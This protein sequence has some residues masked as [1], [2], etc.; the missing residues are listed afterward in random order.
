L[1]LLQLMQIVDVCDSSVAAIDLPSSIPYRLSTDHEPAVDA[2]LPA[3]AVFTVVRP[4]LIHGGPE[5][6]DCVLALVWVDH[7]LSAIA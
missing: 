1:T 6:R 4:F 7:L 3:N 5:A 2:I